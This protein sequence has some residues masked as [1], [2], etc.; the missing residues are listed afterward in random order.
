MQGILYVFEYLLSL[1]KS[2]RPFVV[3]LQS[4]IL[5][6]S[7][8]YPVVKSQH[9][10]TSFQELVELLFEPERE[11]HDLEDDTIRLADTVEPL[12]VIRSDLVALLMMLILFHQR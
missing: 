7:T 3:W 4:Q 2:S 9:F 12:Y 6:N 5:T 10:I 8:A 1:L 11:L